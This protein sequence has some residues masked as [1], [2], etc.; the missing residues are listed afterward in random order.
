MCFA[1]SGTECYSGYEDHVQYHA[2][3]ASA[4][5]Y[6]CCYWRAVV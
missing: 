5:V 6:V 3:H 2:G 1:E 4:T